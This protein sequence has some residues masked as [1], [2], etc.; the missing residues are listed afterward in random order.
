MYKILPETENRTLEEIEL[1]FADN[2]KKLTDRK[3]AIIHDSQNGCEKE[4]NFNEIKSISVIK[5]DDLLTN[6]YSNGYGN[7]RF[8]GNI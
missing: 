8:S 5:S 1:H 3:I 7:R 4:N 6:H 2:S